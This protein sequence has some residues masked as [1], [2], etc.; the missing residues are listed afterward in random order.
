MHTNI[1]RLKAADKEVYVHI[2]L[3]SSNWRT[4]MANW[5]SFGI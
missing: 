5:F 2:L 3:Y 1:F 4:K